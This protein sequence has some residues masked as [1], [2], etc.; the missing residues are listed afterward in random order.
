M[1]IIDILVMRSMKWLRSHLVNLSDAGY[2]I[3]S[4][5]IFD[6]EVIIVRHLTT[7]TMERDE[8]NNG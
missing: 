1:Q 2:T 4:V 5:T 6:G 8:A 7:T 3:D